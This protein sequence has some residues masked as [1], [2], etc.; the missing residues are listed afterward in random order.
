MG[1]AS[2]T[3]GGR[4]PRHPRI[5][6]ELDEGVFQSQ[7]AIQVQVIFP[8]ITRSQFEFVEYPRLVADFDAEDPRDTQPIFGKPEG[9]S[10]AVIGPDQY[11]G[12]EVAQHLVN[13]HSPLHQE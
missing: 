2:I 13:S 5:L 4:A 12:I 6:V 8:H 3:A 1:T 9:G 10:P 11:V 7:F